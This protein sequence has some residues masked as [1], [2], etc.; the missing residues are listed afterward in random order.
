MRKGK[1]MTEKH[2]LEDA[3]REA[4]REEGRRL[5][6]MEAADAAEQAGYARGYAD[7]QDQIEA[8]Q[9]EVA[10]LTAALEK[11]TGCCAGED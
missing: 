11:H 9:A 7:A 1:P 8:L 4:C 5:G 10:A 3:E 6:C 2:I